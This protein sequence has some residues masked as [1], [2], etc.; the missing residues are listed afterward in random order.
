MSASAIDSQLLGQLFADAKMH[1]VFADPQRLQS[2]LDVEAALAKVQA[3]AGLIPQAA[4]KE[5]AANCRAEA[6]DLEA[7]GA[8]TARAGNPVIP[9][10][11][12]LTALSGEDAGRYVHWGA[13]SQDIADTGL[14]LQLRAAWTRIDTLTDALTSDLAKLARSHRDTPMAGRTFMQHAAPITFGFKAASWLSPMLRHRQRIAELRPRMLILQF[15]GAVGT[16]ASL[17]GDGLKL[18]RA[19]AQELDLRLPDMPWHTGRDGLLEA[20]QVMANIAATA[21][22][23]AG[24]VA[25]LMQTEIGEAFEPAGEGRGGSSTMPQKRNP[26]TS[27]AI[28]GANTKLQALIPAMAAGA[29]PDHERGTGAWHGEWLVLPEIMV[30]GAGILARASEIIA[31]IEVDPARMRHNLELTGGLIMAEAAMMALAPALG[32]LEAHHLVSEA[33][34]EASRKGLHLK[35]VLG[36]SRE[37]REHLDDKALSN[38]FDPTRR[39]GLATAFVDRVLDAY[40]DSR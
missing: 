4:A 29:S 24:D 32:R 11:K 3:R 14:V 37:V 26:A 16:L 5:I 39:T 2:M 31:G 6:F 22:K 34:Q 18:A 13:T 9:M 40:D 21:A 7:L 1:E 35:E 25:L 36:N 33:C 19:L 8:A 15:G 10:V 28:L 38:L 30:L 17:G 27:A 23:I 20:A 12:A